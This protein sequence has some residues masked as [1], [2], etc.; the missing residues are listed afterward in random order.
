M[1]DIAGPWQPTV[2]FTGQ[3]AAAGGHGAAWL[4]D[5][6]L[7]LED[8]NDPGA[9]PGSPNDFGGGDGWNTAMTGTSPSA[10]GVFGV[11]GWGTARSWKGWF[12][13]TEENQ[14]DSAAGPE[15]AKLGAGSKT[16]LIALLSV[17]AAIVAPGSVCISK[18]YELKLQAQQQEHANHKGFHKLSFS[19]RKNRI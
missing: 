13:M 14:R 19:L 4:M 8:P 7:L 16:V 10:L 6:M 15:R 18:Q 11:W 1:G 9:F 5:Q 3:Y 17:L 2:E 12:A